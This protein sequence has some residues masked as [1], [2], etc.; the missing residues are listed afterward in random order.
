[1]K[2][3]SN[4]KKGNTP[5]YPLYPANEDIYNQFQKE[6]N[7]NPDENPEKEDRVGINKF[8]T[9]N[10]QDFEDHISENDMDIPGSELDDEQ[11]NIGNED[12][13]NNYYS[14]GGEN[15]H[16]LDEDQGL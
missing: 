10:P 13:E 8:G 14:L 1:M 16:D 5:G 9:D 2:D 4:H 6:E 11:E 15:H 7:I 3:K 12:E